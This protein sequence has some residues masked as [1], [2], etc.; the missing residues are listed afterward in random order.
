MILYEITTNNFKHFPWSLNY[1]LIFVY[2]ISMHNVRAWSVESD[3]LQ[4][5]GL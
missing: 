2:I 5:H 1:L 4:L 3:Y